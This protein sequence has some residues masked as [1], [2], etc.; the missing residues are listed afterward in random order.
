MNSQQ[1]L[2]SLTGNLTSNFTVPYLEADES[3]S[4]IEYG[5]RTSIGTTSADFIIVDST[6][7]SSFVLNFYGPV[8]LT[9]NPS[10]IQ[11]PKKINRIVYSFT[12][13]SPNIVHSF[14]YAPT[15]SDT[16]NYPYPLEPGDPR[17]FPITKTFYSSQYFIQSF[18]VLAE[19]YQ[20]GI[21]DPSTVR[22][23]INIIAPR[24]D[25]KN[26]DGSVTFEE[27]NLISNRMFG[28]NDDIFYV[29]E[30]KNPRYVLPVLINWAQKPTVQILNTN[31]APTPNSPIKLLQPFE[32]DSLNNNSNINIVPLVNSTN[33]I[34]ERGGK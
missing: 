14:Y 18:T 32:L 4:A 9:F 2:L 20:F 10:A 7:V 30:T 24:I 17:N 25:G 29:F 6:F 11:L 26:S 33:T 8:T 16:A 15:S 22:Y 21:T 13:S 23:D 34:A 12:D 31:I 19:I 3:Y 27:T 28:V 5:D 1:V